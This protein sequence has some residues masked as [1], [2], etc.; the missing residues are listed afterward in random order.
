ML[1]TPGTTSP[2]NTFS[3][4]IIL[5]LQGGIGNQLF[6]YAY[7]QA[8]SQKTGQKIILDTSSYRHNIYRNFVLNELNV[9]YSLNIPSKA[10][11]KILRKI[12]HPEVIVDTHKFQAL[13]NYPKNIELAGF[14]E[15]YKY[16]SS[17]D[18]LIRKEFTFKKP[19]QIFKDD[20]L[21]NFHRVLKSLFHCK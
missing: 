8:V 3:H 5:P 11:S 16:F 1:I 9:S 17:I 19:R 20:S 13:E 15:S 4:M 10:V 7:A 12:V 18:S 14:W 6:Q 2:S 21:K